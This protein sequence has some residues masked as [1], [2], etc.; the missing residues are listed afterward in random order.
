MRNFFRRLPVYLVGMV[1]IN[2]ITMSYSWTEW[3]MVTCILAL[4]VFGA[5]VACTVLTKRLVTVINA[6]LKEF[7]LWGILAL[8]LAVVS[9][10]ERFAIVCVANAP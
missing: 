9:C 8:L 10:R 1:A 3:L 4:A 6:T 5:E 2:A 7:L